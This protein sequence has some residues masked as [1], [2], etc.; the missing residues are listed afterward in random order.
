MEQEGGIHISGEE[1]VTMWR[2]QWKCTSWQ[3]WREYTWKNLIGYF[4]PP[5]QKSH[6][7]RTP[8]YM[9]EELW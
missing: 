7:D 5:S 2:Y 4:I 6:Y 9:L 8:P 3:N 1:W